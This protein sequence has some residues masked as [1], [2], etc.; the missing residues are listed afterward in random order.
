[1]PEKAKIKIIKRDEIVPQKRKKRK[2][3]SAHTPAREMVATVGE[4]V[5]DLKKRKGE[6][7]KA[8]VDMLL[9]RT[10]LPNES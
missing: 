6:E 10:R 4:W 8:A 3:E 5:A 2:V 9:G 1:M 7:T